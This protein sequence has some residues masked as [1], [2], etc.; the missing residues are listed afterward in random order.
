MTQKIAFIFGLG[1]TGKAIARELI[2]NGWH[3]R[4]TTRNKD[5]LGGASLGVELAGVELVPF[6]AGT[7]IATPAGTPIATPAPFQGVSHVISTIPVIDGED[8]V[9]ATHG[10]DLRALNCWT[11]Y[12]SATSVYSEANGGWVNEESPTNPISTRGQLRRMAEI[13]WQET[14]GSEI[15]RAAGIYGPGRSPFTKLLANKAR[16]IHKPGHLFNRIHVD[17]IARIVTTAMQK[18]QAL[19]IINLADGAPCE[20]GDVIRYGAELLGVAPPPPV[21]FEDAELSPMARSFYATA[22]CV[23]STKIKHALGIDLLYPDYRAGMRA[24]LEAEMATGIL[25]K[26]CGSSA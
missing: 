18:P 15:F 9:L 3:V 21:A 17:D 5:A 16:I 12:I 14:L 6:S 23:D 1:F 26:S 10:N 8:C 7:P 2:K 24:V 25:P 11:G 19:R 4:A 20:A 13:K 22:R